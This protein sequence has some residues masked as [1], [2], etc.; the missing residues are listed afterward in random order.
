MQDVGLETGNKFINISLVWKQVKCEKM[1]N[2]YCPLG[3]PYDK[4]ALAL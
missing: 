2:E 1:P 4:S 3:L